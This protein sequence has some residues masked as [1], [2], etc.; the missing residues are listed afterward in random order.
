MLNE[1]WKEDV[2]EK[3]EQMLVGRPYVIVV[4]DEPTTKVPREPWVMKSGVP[5]WV[6]STVAPGE[7][8]EKALEHIRV[9]S[10]ESA[11]AG[12]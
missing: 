2:A 10:E 1:K 5:Y 6:R 7:G 3:L 9:V 4:Y 12:L 11:K 8:V